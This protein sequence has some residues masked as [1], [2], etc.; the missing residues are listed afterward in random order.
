MKTQM[1]CLEDG[2]TSCG[3]RKM[4]AY[5]AQLEPDTESV[6]ISTE[7]Y[8]SVKAAVRGMGDKGRMP[9]EQVD[10]IAQGLKG[11]DLVGFSSMTGY[12]D[13]THRVIKR[14]RELNPSTYIVWGGIH[15]IIQ[16]EDAIL[17]DV[18]AV[19]T[20]EGEFA[21]EELL[22][23]LKEGRD[24]TKTKNFWF[25]PTNGNGG[26][27]IIKNHF[28]P[29]MTVQEMESLPFPQYGVDSEKI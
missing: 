10:E 7:R 22:Q 17:G 4:A 1:V 6:Y 28:L 8:R 24:V 19:C 2:I 13:L 20:G 18:D 9:D 12:A 21:F 27:E 5:V 11:S 26:Q 23:G 3:F 29:L 25:K 14:L 15:P 16:P